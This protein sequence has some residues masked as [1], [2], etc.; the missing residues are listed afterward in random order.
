M[1]GHM[2]RIAVRP[3]LLVSNVMPKHAKAMGA[4]AKHNQP[5]LQVVVAQ[6]VLMLHLQLLLVE[7]IKLAVNVLA[8]LA[9]VSKTAL[10]PMAK[11]CVAVSRLQLV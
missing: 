2:D 8:L 1:D 5:L 11:F 6:H 4:V 7:A 9:L 3:M 10:V